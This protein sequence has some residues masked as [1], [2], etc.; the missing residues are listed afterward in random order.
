MATATVV[1]PHCGSTGTH[2]HGIGTGSGTAHGQCKQ[3]HKTF[4]IIIRKGQV[5]EV[6]R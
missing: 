5:H 1:C 3:C 4:K 6:R 2:N